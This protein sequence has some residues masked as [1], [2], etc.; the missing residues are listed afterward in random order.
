MDSPCFLHFLVEFIHCY[1]HKEKKRESDVEK[2][3]CVQLLSMLNLH[4]SQTLSQ[5]SVWG[6]KNETAIIVI[7]GLRSN[8]VGK[9]RGEEKFWQLFLWEDLIKKT[10][11]RLETD[12]E[13]VAN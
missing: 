3:K 10:L 4:Q 9:R 6:L 11:Q 5:L 12:G 2:K 7:T 1:F 8:I 13:I